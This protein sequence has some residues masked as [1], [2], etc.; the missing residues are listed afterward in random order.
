MAKQTKLI[1]LILFLFTVGTVG[2]RSPEQT[3]DTDSSTNPGTALVSGCP[4][5]FSAQ[6]DNSMAPYIIRS[7]WIL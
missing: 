2:C 6:F 4:D 5:G 1:V 7:D 3:E